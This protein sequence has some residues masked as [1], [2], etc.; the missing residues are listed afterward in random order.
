MK[1]KIYIILGVD[2]SG[3][4]LLSKALIDQ[5][6]DMGE[7]LKKD[8]NINKK[9]FES[10]DFV[11]L[12]NEILRIAKGTW[13]NPPSQ[14]NLGQAG[15]VYEI[16]EKIKKVVHKESFANWGWNDPKTCLTLPYFL[17]H[18]NGDVHLISI[19]RKPLLAAKSLKRKNGLSIKRG[20]EL[21]VEYNQRLL[22]HIRSF[23]GL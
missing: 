8:N 11:S 6:I 12:N 5:G 16:K 20:M 9:S 7:R 22:E 10:L 2:Y 23:I 17:E 1:Q 3:T 4:C 14:Y 18:L 13:D 15:R 21:V 19:F